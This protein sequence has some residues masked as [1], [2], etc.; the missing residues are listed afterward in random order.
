MAESHVSGG[1]S[2]TPASLNF[3][4]ALAAGRQR[5]T[6]R[7]EPLPCGVPAL[8]TGD[9]VD[10]RVPQIQQMLG[11]RVGRLAGADARGHHA[12]GGEGQR[13]AVD[14]DGHV[15]ADELRPEASARAALLSR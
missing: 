12:W 15:G 4:P 13:S 14:E 11:G 7:R 5:G 1:S 9:V 10:G 2:K 6:P 3:V 8:L